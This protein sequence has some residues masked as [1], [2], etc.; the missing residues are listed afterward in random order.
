MDPKK[1]P[2]RSD[3]W[4]GKVPQ[5]HFGGKLLDKVTISFSLFLTFF[6]LFVFWP[7]ISKLSFQE[8]FDTPFVPFLI[9]TFTVFNVD[10]N[11]SLR[12]LFI[13]SL[14][15]AGLGIYLLVRDL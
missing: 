14:A 2:V 15:M 12:I 6:A 11:G 13:L 10:A 5:V 3:L 8:A 1:I 4:F 9:Q 7:V